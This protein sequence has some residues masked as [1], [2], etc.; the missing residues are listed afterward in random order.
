MPGID[1]PVKFSIY[2][3]IGVYGTWA[4]DWAADFISI[5]FGGCARAGVVITVFGWE[6]RR[7]VIQRWGDEFAL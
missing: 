2:G 6:N 5:G 4:Y 1:A 7:E 3:M